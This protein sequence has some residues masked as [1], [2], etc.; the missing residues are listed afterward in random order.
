[1]QLGSFAESNEDGT[2]DIY[3]AVFSPDGKKIVTTAADKTAK[4]WDAQTKKVTFDLI[5]H[6]DVI[7]SSVFSADGKRIA[8]ASAD[9]TA[10]IWDVESGKLITNLKGHKSAVYS[11][12]FSP[13]GKK[14]V[15]ASRD[16]TAKIWLSSEGIIDWLSGEENI[17]NLAQD[18]ME[19]LGIDFIDIND[20][21][22]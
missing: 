12:I 11:A 6:Q 3:R 21:L 14:I 2:I 20:K 8:T 19:E 16:N 15:T 1:M 18:H 9:G 17:P 5:G 10:K 22:R 13:D 7:L 4:M